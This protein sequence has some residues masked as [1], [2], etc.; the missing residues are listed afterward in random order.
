MKFHGKLVGFVICVIV[1]HFCYVLVF[2]TADKCKPITDPHD[3]D[4]LERLV[5]ALPP[6]FTSRFGEIVWAAGGQGFGWWPGCI[7]DP[8]LTVGS[9]RELARKNL[10]KKHLVYFFECHEAPFSVMV[11]SRLTPWDEGLSQD[12]HLGRGARSAGKNRAQQFEHALQAAIVENDKPVEMRLE[13]NHPD[14]P[15]VIPSP[16]RKR[17]PSSKGLETGKRGRKKGNDQGS[18]DRK[19]GQRQESKTV[20]LKSK[21]ARVTPNRS[22]LN[23]AIEALAAAN[24]IESHEDG[25]L[26]LKILKKN[27]PRE[28]GEEPDVVESVGFVKLESRLS[29]T[30]ADAR[31]AIA[32]ELDPDSMPNMVRWK[33]YIPTLGPMSIKQETKVGPMLEFLKNTTSDARLG[34]G[35]IRH[36]LKVIIMGGSLGTAEFPPS[37]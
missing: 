17:K 32:E 23:S 28:D 36:P 2:P 30:F 7:Y 18:E 29:S 25:E 1:F 20:S 9:A 24:E 11:N 4:G 3:D 27:P 15:Q 6:A 22:N 8:R 10:G 33:F 31:L 35:S 12:F 26:Y 13:W 21:F 19:K 14:V 16:K 37:L 34:N 5:S